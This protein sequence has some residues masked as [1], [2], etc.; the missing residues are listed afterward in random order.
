MKQFKAFRG[1]I[2]G[3]F[4]FII[5]A[6]I[7]TAL[8][9]F[10][11]SVVNRIQ[12]I[13]TQNIGEVQELYK[14]SVQA[15]FNDLF[16]ML[17]A[18]S[19]YFNDTDTSNPDSLK[20]TITRTK[21]IGE[22]KTISIANKDG[23]CTD[24]TGQSLPNVFN[25]DYFK[26]TILSAQK[27]ISNKIELDENLEPIL[28][29]SYPIE[30]GNKTDAV[31]LGTLSYNVLKN[32]FNVSIFDGQSYSYLI[33]RDG[34]IILC[35]S[36][37]KKNLYN[38]NFYTYIQNNT[39]KQKNQIQKIKTD[40]IKNNKS[41]VFFNGAE[42]TRMLA[43]EPLNIND[44]YIVSVVPFSYIKAQ[45][46]AIETPVFVILFIIAIT[47]LI[48]IL[49]VYVLYKTNYT[50]EKDN[51][52][53]IIANTQT[54]SL[55]FEYDIA[56]GTVDFSGD[57]KFIL[58]GE[59]KNF[60]IQYVRAEYYKR[61]HPD[62]IRFFEHLKDSLVQ[63]LEDF[64][65]EF[66]YKNYNEEYIWVRMTGTT[67]CKPNGE[68]EKFIGSIINVNA[69]VMH[70]QELKSMAERDKLTTLLNKSA[71]EYHAKKFFQ[72]EAEN[73]VCALFVIDLDNFKLVND[74]L[75]HLI[76]DQA[77]KDAA[78]KLS[79]IFSE[80]DLISRFGGDEFCVL[81]RLNGALN[82]ETVDRIIK[83]K[84]QTVCT[85]I[86]EYYSDEKNTIQVTSSVGIALYPEQ[87]TTYEELFRKADEALYQVKQNGKNHFKIYN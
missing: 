87:S 65:S 11:S 2:L 37:K 1:F 45:R 34:N 82:K 78:N 35:N 5:V 80:K 14:Q 79:L 25:K 71:M 19:R 23:A 52:R 43:Y 41:Y 9:V 56:K 50:I 85:M 44:W 61:I 3:F 70:E 38:V 18:Q 39:Q 32:L 67:V 12:K 64:S 48:F 59:R 77:I 22:F 47:I 28:T 57:L 53:L 49:A 7:S 72:Q 68:V 10:H 54:Q 63:H 74:T 20:R 86:N 73:N 29:L 4:L 83:E 40:I 8:I 6:L 30:N 84:A 60:T 62:D 27:Q 51:E 31:L 66:R 58:G 24:Y 21:G 15:K 17:E 46:S 13:T 16:D 33:T 76:G 75:G 36:N 69:Q 26:D 55:I 81:L 42:G